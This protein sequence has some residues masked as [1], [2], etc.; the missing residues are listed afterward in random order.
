M[1]SKNVRNVVPW[2]TKSSLPRTFCNNPC[3]NATHPREKIGQARVVTGSLKRQAGKLV[4][5]N[6]HKF[7]FA[8]RSV[9]QSK[10]AT[11]TELD[12]VSEAR[13][14]SLRERRVYFPGVARTRILKVD[15][16]F[17]NVSCITREEKEKKR[18]DQKKKEW[19]KRKEKLAITTRVVT[20]RTFQTGL[21]WPTRT[22][23]SARSSIKS[24]TVEPSLFWRKRD[25]V[26]SRSFRATW[27]LNLLIV[28]SGESSDIS[29]I[30]VRPYL[31][32]QT[33]ADK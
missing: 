7:V 10:S 11:V 23:K 21:C 20:D 27:I 6:A 1:C 8:K 26:G 16:R 32:R 15:S 29:R 12:D 24:G 4:G 17:I 14:R 2:C 5:N 3:C 33:K 31:T 28:E 25:L 30:Y 13:G 22:I 19:N 18:K 9:L